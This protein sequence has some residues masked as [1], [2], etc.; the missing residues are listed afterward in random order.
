M[1]L[2][3]DTLAHVDEHRDAGTT[4]DHLHDEHGLTWELAAELDREAL[5]ASAEHLGLHAVLELAEA[6][7]WA[8]PLPELCHHS[9]A[10]AAADGSYMCVDCGEPF[11]SQADWLARSF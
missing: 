8:E 6:E 10:A 9:A 11:A 1:Q 3:P 5:F 2:S 4:F 7:A